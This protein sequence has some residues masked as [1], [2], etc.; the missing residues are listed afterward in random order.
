MGGSKVGQL[1]LLML[2]LGLGRTLGNREAQ[3]G[4]VFNCKLGEAALGA[5]TVVVKE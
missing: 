2:G 4:K 3:V 5:G 1:Q